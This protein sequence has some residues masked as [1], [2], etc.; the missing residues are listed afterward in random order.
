MALFVPDSEIYLLK[1]IPFTPDYRNTG[2]FANKDTQGAIMQTRAFYHA[3]NCTY[4]R[5]TGRI[6]LE[7]PI[8]QAWQCNYIMYRNTNFYNKWFYAF[9][10]AVNYINNE[11]SELT[12][13]LDIMQTF[14][15]DY[16]EKPCFIERQHAANDAL[17]SNLVPEG[18]EIGELTWAAFSKLPATYGKIY[19]AATFD[20]QLNNYNGGMFNNVYTGLC[21]NE[22]NTAAE[23]TAFINSA[24]SANKLS[25]IVSIFQSINYNTI[26]TFNYNINQSALF[27]GYTPRNNKLYT[28]PYTFLQILG[29]DGGNAIFRWEYFNQF[30]QTAFQIATSPSISSQMLITP[31]NYKNKTGYNPAER[32]IIENVMLCSWNGDTYKANLAQTVGK[33]LVPAEVAIVTGAGLLDKIVG[34]YTTNASSNETIDPAGVNLKE[35]KEA[36]RFSNMLNFLQEDTGI[37]GK[38]N[39]GVQSYYKVK[40]SET[41]EAQGYFSSAASELS[42]QVLNTV[43]TALAAI[44]QP[45]SMARQAQNPG[46]STDILYMLQEKSPYFVQMSI[47]PYYAKIIDDYFTMY[48]Y[49]TNR[50]QNPNRRARTRYTYIKTAGAIIEAEFPASIAQAIENIYNNGICFW[51]IT[52][53][54]QNTLDGVGNYENNNPIA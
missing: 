28:Y 42:K 37:R 35:A 15:F 52:G 13:Q 18:L 22:F 32:M 8:A 4:V 6:R 41:T 16:T 14:L 40:P 47:T 29:N 43:Q 33:Y 27:G 36:T 24:T 12:F 17:G 46:A 10:T 26:T 53:T 44:H 25:G 39:N 20:K 23:V 7:I 48:G 54:G 38:V 2:L 30:G 3:Q 45:E 9:V 19:V 51:W 50:V 49:Q 11:T 5:E 21:I 34:Q 31:T 1:N